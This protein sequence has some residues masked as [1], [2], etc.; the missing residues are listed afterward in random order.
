MVPMQPVR[1]CATS[2]SS[3]TA[4]ASSRP[5]AVRLIRACMGEI[6]LTT[7]RWSGRTMMFCGMD[8][9]GAASA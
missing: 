5:V 7:P 3:A 1:T 2:E 9:Y 8:D 4:R 6:P